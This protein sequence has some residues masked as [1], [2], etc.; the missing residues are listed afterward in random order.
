[1]VGSTGLQLK[2]DPGVPLVYVG[3]ALC[4]VTSIMSLWP[5]RQVWAIQ[6]DEALLLIGGKTN[7]DQVGFEDAMDVMLYTMK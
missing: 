5:Y 6:E 4:L 1:M 7:R 3:F 2:S